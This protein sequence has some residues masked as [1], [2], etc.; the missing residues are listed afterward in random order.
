VLAARLQ[1][2]AP[3]ILQLILQEV[4]EPYRNSVR[5]DWLSSEG[6][7]ERMR[8]E[9]LSKHPEVAAREQQIIERIG[10]DPPHEIQRLLAEYR[11]VWDAT[12]ISRSI[13]GEEKV[14]YL[15]HRFGIAPTYVRS[16]QVLNIVYG[17]QYGG[18][19]V[20]QCVIH[21]IRSRGRLVALTHSL[22][23]EGILFEFDMARL[24]RWLGTR[25]GRTLDE[26][27]LNAILLRHRGED[28]AADPICRE[29]L[30][31]IHTFSHLMLRESEV[32]TGY[33]RDSLAELI[34][35]PL[36]AF[37]IFAEEGN[38]LGVLETACRSDNITN[39][40]MASAA[41]AQSCLLDPVCGQGEITGVAACHSC[42]FVGERNCN[43]L[44]NEFLDRRY[45]RYYF[46]LS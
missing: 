9:Y 1:A 34:F 24:A 17:R 5:K 43:G 41:N 30:A 8:Q 25:H 10:S 2:E 26:A 45:V 42:C 19:N 21:P 7:R 46:E 22:E 33:S 23:T 18:S 16:I 44:W 20:D 11:G 39:W 40:L 38:E 13:I 31:L 29:A 14:R 12:Q 27:G 3:D 36:G 6:S 15:R 28:P 37:V 32:H 4:P 35:S